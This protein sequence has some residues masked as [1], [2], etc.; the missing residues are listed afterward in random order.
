MNSTFCTCPR[1]VRFFLSNFLVRPGHM[2]L[3]TL[4]MDEENAKHFLLR[5][6]VLTSRGIC[7]NVNWRKGWKS[8]LIDKNIV[9]R[10]NRCGIFPTPSYMIQKR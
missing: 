1:E 3:K 9:I 8:F 7:M 2:F 10:K 4:D 5:K 6:G